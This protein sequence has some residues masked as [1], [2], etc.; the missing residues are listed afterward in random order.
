M[1]EQK[2]DDSLKSRV[3]KIW[4]L[5]K[6]TDKFK[7]NI[8]SHAFESKLIF[9]QIY[10]SIRFEVFQRSIDKKNCVINVLIEMHALFSI[11]LDKGQIISIK[12]GIW[13][14]YFFLSVSV[15]QKIKSVRVFNPYLYI[16]IGEYNSGGVNTFVSYVSLILLNIFFIHRRWLKYELEN[17]P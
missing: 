8:E 15:Y 4:V 12:T 5:R 1:L 11:Y 3:T 14:C 7:S 10:Y 2:K 17:E 9:I 6:S 16:W 13:C